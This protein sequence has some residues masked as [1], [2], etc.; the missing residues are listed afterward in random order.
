[1]RTVAEAEEWVP[2]FTGQRPPF[3]EGNTVAARH[4]AYSDALVRPRAREVADR[5]AAAGE[6]PPYLL[7][8]PS[9]RQAVTSYTT[10]LA[11][12]EAVEEWL[13]GH[14]VDG[15]PVEVD[16]EGAVRGAAIL[17]DRLRNR[18][19]KEREQLGLTPLS[20]AKLGK[21]IAAARVDVAAWLAE[22]RAAAEGGATEGPGGAS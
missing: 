11:R 14:A 21:D 6:L 9:Y 7:S 2:A 8:D 10:T 17:L 22:Q 19:M 4:G 15:R 5:M 16:D 18:A 12:I 13:E 3:T 1:M 20:R